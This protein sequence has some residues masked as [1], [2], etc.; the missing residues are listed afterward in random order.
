M[1]S[2]PSQSSLTLQ[3]WFTRVEPSTTAIM[4]EDFL[5]PSEKERLL[6]TGSPYKRQEYLLSRMLM[7]H[8]LSQHFLRPE[9]DWLFIERKNLPPIINNL[10]SNIYVSLSHSDGFICFA[11]SSSPIGVDVE[12]G[13]ENRNFKALAKSFMTNEE[14]HYLEK[15]TE[16]LS[17]IFYRTWCAKEAYYKAIPAIEQRE[18]SYKDIPVRALTNNEEK[19]YLTEGKIEEFFI[20]V[21]LKKKP[22]NI[23]CNYFPKE[24][25][26]Y[27][28]DIT[29]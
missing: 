9:K 25:N 29:S 3:L 26:I 19:W 6:L 14:L 13:K 7:R 4:T 23:I 10:P 18:I 22:E 2:T 24:C 28:L 11:L 20:A 15:N 12:N 21:I 1:S 5:S 27:H 17:N 16:N 8:A